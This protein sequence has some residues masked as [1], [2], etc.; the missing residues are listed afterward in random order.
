LGWI[1]VNIVEN[2]HLFRADY[3]ATAYL[4]LE[5]LKERQMK[6]YHEF[7]EKCRNDIKKQMK[8][9]K[10]ILELRHK[11]EKLIKLQL[12]DKAEKIEGDLIFKTLFDI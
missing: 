12:Y 5:K 4:S 11:Y 2:L 9:S 10:D 3:E 6:E 8:F 1:H 7:Q